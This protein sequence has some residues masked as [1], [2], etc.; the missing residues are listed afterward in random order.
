MSFSPEVSPSFLCEMNRQA[1]T[2][3]EIS[4]A[5]DFL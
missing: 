4:S 5:I 2:L 1:L 3:G